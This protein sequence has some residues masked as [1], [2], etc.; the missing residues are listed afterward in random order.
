MNP[1]KVAEGLALARAERAV[2]K[3]GRRGDRCERA[4]LDV[5]L[6]CWK[7]WVNTGPESVGLANP[8]CPACVRNA[9]RRKREVE[10]SR[11]IG[12]LTGALTRYGLEKVKSKSGN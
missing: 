3:A 1:A 10:L 6:P 2:I 11:K 12:A 4:E 7:D 9:G 8:L 5:A